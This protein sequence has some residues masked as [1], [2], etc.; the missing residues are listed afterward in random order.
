[1]G[2]TIRANLAVAAGLP[3]A[4]AKSFAICTALAFFATT[5]QSGF[6]NN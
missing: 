4:T 6:D 5:A 2:D 1:M 3:H